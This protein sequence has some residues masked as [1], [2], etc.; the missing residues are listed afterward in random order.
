MG[1]NATNTREWNY[2]FEVSDKPTGDVEGVGISLTFTDPYSTVSSPAT[3]EA[4]VSNDTD[5]EVVIRIGGAGL[6]HPREDTSSELYLYSPSTELEHEGDGVWVPS[7][8]DSIPEYYVAMLVREPI[9]AGEELTRRYRVGVSPGGDDSEYPTGKIEFDC[10]DRSF[11]SLDGSFQMDFE[12]E[13][14]KRG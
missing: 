6:V 4:V 13:S 11:D 10:E 3:L 12:I 1:V 8:L 2:R 5:S 7:D 9:P 14:A